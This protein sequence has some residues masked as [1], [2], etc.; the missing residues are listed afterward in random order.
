MG[1]MQR[2]REEESIFEHILNTHLSERRYEVEDFEVAFSPEASPRSLP[3]QG[4]LDAA[5]A[6]RRV[7]S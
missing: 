6:Q 3:V 7:S 4:C 2:T 5:E 1:T